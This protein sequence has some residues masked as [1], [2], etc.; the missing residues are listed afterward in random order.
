MTNENLSDSGDKRTIDTIYR[1]LC[2][3]KSRGSENVEKPEGILK[4]V[5]YAI[6]RCA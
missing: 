5:V 1:V 4:V 3:H 6:E 2:P